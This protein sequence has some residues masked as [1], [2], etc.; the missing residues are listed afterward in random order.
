M[1]SAP[2]DMEIRM[3]RTRQEMEWKGCEWKGCEWKGCEWKGKIEI[4]Q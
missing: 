4:W 2:R 1:R 3:A